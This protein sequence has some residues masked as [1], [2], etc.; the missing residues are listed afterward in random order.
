MK[1][2]VKICGLTRAEDV[3]G[4]EAAG[5][6]FLG[7]IVE[8]KSKRRLSVA[9]AAALIKTVKTNTVAVTGD[10]SDQ[11]VADIKAAGFSHIQLHGWESLARVAEIARTG[12]SVIKAVP[13]DSRDEVAL[14]TDFS[15]AADLILFDAKPAP[16][17]PKDAP[18]GGHG[19]TF[20]WSILKGAAMPKRWALA[21]GLTPN[22]VAKAIRRT[23]APIVDVASG[24]EISPGIKDAA[25]I[26]AFI[27]N[28]KDTYGPG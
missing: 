27:A 10:P 26:Q 12:L 20:D 6:D 18:R 9:Q 19:L 17:A 2:Q 7:F 13:V 22:T 25:L 21:G 14:A 11:L 5:A 8:V 23:K 1:T 4:A 24:V 28:A 15:G 3:A 16:D